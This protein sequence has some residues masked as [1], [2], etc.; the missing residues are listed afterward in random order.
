[1]HH[2]ETL[3]GRKAFISI[4]SLI[5]KLFSAHATPNIL[6]E[7]ETKRM[8]FTRIEQSIQNTTLHLPPPPPI[9]GTQGRR[10]ALFETI[11]QP[12]LTLSFPS[13]TWTPLC[14]I[15]T[16]VCMCSLIRTFSN[17]LNISFKRVEKK[18][19]LKNHSCADVKLHLHQGPSLLFA[20]PNSAWPFPIPR[21]C[22]AQP[23]EDLHLNKN[24]RSKTSRRNTC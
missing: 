6:N 7:F 12:M 20:D 3:L 21:G 23:V 22:I 14:S 15:L 24:T 11:S 8:N 17:T 13:M 18:K 16:I 10:E 5:G 1:M 4:A 19:G 2:Y 9:I